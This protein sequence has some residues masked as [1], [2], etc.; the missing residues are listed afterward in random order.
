MSTDTLTCADVSDDRLALIVR[1]IE[2]IYRRVEKMKV[3]RLSREGARPLQILC[4]SE[5]AGKD[6]PSRIASVTNDVR[7]LEYA[8]WCM[9]VSLMAVGGKALMT[10]V[11]NA[12]SEPNGIYAARFS[13]WLD[14]RWSNVAD[15]HERWTA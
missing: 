9:G 3:E 15:G 10:R 6:V 12:V 5:W 1:R 7:G 11:Y 8:V 13:S 14:H 4:P 2:V